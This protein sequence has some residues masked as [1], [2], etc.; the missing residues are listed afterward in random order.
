MEEARRNEEN[1]DRD[2]DNKWERVCKN[3]D[4]SS[5]TRPS[6]HDLSRMKTAMINRKNDMNDEAAQGTLKTLKW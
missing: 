5:S 4:L 6:G 2:I 1:R 3:C